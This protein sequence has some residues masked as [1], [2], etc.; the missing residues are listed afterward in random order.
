MLKNVFYHHYTVKLKK[1][2]FVIVQNITVAIY[3]NQKLSLHMVFKRMQ[4]MTF[5]VQVEFITNIHDTKSMSIKVESNY[6][7][8]VCVCELFCASEHS[9]WY[10]THISKFVNHKFVII[11]EYVVSVGSQSMSNLIHW[12]CIFCIVMTSNMS[13]F[14]NAYG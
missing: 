10:Y 6:T 5:T 1:G 12:K 11:T 13:F 9:L 8:C 7:V 2:E 14:T 4:S 3:L